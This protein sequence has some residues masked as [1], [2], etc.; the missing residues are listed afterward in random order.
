MKVGLDVL[1]ERMVA[2][3]TP[4]SQRAWLI[5]NNRDDPNLRDSLRKENSVRR[6]ARMERVGNI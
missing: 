6:S 5:A 4:I 3:G 1:P 2:D